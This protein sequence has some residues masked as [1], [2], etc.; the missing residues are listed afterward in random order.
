MALRASLTIMCVSFVCA[1]F[2]MAG[3][4]RDWLLHQ[5]FQRAAGA[6]YIN[7]LI[8]GFLRLG[9]NLARPACLVPAYWVLVRKIHACGCSCVWGSS[10][11]VPSRW[12]VFPATSACPVP[13][14][15]AGSWKFREED[16]TF[17]LDVLA[18]GG[19]ENTA[20]QWKIPRCTLRTHR[21]EGIK[22][23]AWGNKELTAQYG[24][25]GTSQWHCDPHNVSHKT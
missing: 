24:T 21:G 5:R 18:G 11:P 25:H 19:H 2:L 9:L 6:R 3:F 20:W 1:R 16:L 15:R 17:L 12:L 8:A 22:C 13:A 4:L 7:F 10:K 14:C 23:T